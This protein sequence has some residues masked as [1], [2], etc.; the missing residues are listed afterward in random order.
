[1]T[2]SKRPTAIVVGPSFRLSFR[3]D[4]AR[5][6]DLERRQRA[7]LGAG[8]G[9]IATAARLSKAGFAVQIFEKVR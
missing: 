9:G 6:T 8:I 2:S 1:M 5:T 3:P 7:R 4:P